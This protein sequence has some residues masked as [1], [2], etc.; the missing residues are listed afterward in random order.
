[1]TAHKRK[2][3]STGYTAPILG[4]RNGEPHSES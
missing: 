2:D 1:M 3:G 4:M